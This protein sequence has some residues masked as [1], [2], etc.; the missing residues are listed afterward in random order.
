VAKDHQTKEHPAFVAYEDLSLEEKR[1]DYLFAAVCK[2]FSQSDA[3]E[4]RKPA[5]SK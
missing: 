2:A 5:R 3:E 1:K 4:G